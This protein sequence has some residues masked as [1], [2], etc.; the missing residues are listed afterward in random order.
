[1]TNRWYQ[2]VSLLDDLITDNDTN[3]LPG[4]NGFKGLTIDTFF[5]QLN[6]SLPDGANS[7]GT[8]TIP[9]PSVLTL[10]VG[11][12]AFDISV[13]GTKIA[14]ATIPD[15]VLQPGNHSHTINVSSNLTAVVP[16]LSEPAYQCGIL[17]VDILGT[18]SVYD[19]KLL[20]YFTR[21]QAPPI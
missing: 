21:S 1:M 3:N 14:N 16:L 15:L 11:D 17:P 9:N 6:S 2:K 8:V 5:L 19:G 18:A 4:L 7:N 10:A 12:A 13:N 20:P